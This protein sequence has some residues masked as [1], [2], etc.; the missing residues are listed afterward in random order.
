MTKELEKCLEDLQNCNNELEMW[1]DSLQELSD[2]EIAFE[3]DERDRLHG[4]TILD[5]G[6]NCVKPLYI[7]L[8]FEPDK[9][10]G[11]DENLSYSFAS[12]LEQKSR[13]FAKTEI[14]LYNCSLFDEETLRKVLIKEKQVN[15][16]FVLVSKTLHHLRDGE[17]VAEERD[18]KHKHRKDEKHCIY[19]FQERK[20]FKKLFEL[21]QRV[22]IHENFYPEEEDND[23]V[24][25]RGGYFTMEE[26]KR[27]LTHLSQNYVV[28]FIKPIRVHLD[29]KVLEKVVA[30]LRQVDSVFFYVKKSP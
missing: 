17:C 18:K 14:K 12:D 10:I 4:K 1:T 20:I 9:I 24:R 22:I 23:K 13:S 19:E 11:I 3:P 7:A 6:T 15:F 25:G 26:W 29:P 28:E 16:D 5:I 8:R 2:I 21:G 30:K 27:I